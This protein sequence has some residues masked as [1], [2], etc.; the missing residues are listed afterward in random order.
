MGDFGGKL[1]NG[2]ERVGLSRPEPWVRTNAVGQWVTNTIDVVSDEVTYGVG[3]RWGQWAA[4]GGSSLELMD[5]H[6]DHRLAYNWG[7]SDETHKAPWVTVEHTGVLDNGWANPAD[8]LQIMMLDD[9]ECLVDDVEVFAGTNANAIVNST[10]ETGMSG[11]MAQ[12]A[13]VQSRVA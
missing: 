6:S 3:G 10:F 12:G 9:G 7:D 8:A 4:G 1:A 2:G 11:W 5:A 13:L